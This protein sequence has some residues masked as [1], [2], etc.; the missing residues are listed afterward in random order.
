VALAQW[1]IPPEQVGRLTLADFAQLTDAIDAEN[2]SRTQQAA[3]D[4]R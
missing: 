2:R 3:H 4:G 1:N